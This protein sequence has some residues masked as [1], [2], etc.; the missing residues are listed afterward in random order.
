MVRSP[1]IRQPRQSCPSDQKKTRTKPDQRDHGINHVQTS[2]LDLSRTFSQRNHPLRPTCFLLHHLPARTALLT[3]IPA[4]NIQITHVAA[5]TVVLRNT[6]RSQVLAHN[7][8]IS[9]IALVRRR[10]LAYRS[11]RPISARDENYYLDECTHDLEV[12]HVD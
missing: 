3:T 12:S 9:H 8:V 5:K 10:Y 2:V 4:P 1:H 6:T 7:D 11:D